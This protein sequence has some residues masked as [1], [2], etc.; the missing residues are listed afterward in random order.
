MRVLSCRWLSLC[1]FPILALILPGAAGAQTATVPVAA[2]TYLRSGSANQNQGQEILLRLQSSGRNRA[3]LRFDQAAIAAAVGSG[4]LVSAH[5]ELVIAGNGDNWGPDGRTVDAH[6]LSAAWTEVGATWNCPVDANPGNSQPDCAAQWDGGGFEE[7]PSDTVLHTNGQAG[8]VRFEVTA[9]VRAFLAGTA[10]QGWLI[11]KTDEGQN[12]RVDYGSRQ[13]PAG[14]AP[15]LVLVVESAAFDQVPPAL[16]ITEPAAVVINDTTPQVAV[17]YGDGGSG[18]APASLLVRVD[19]VLAAC[20]AG[21]A[22][23]VCEPAAAL[24]AGGHTIEARIADQAGNVATASRGFDLLIG[25]GFASTSVP[26]VADTTLR[27]GQPNQPQGAESVLRVRQ[28]GRNRALVRFDGAALAAALGS[29]TLRSASL[30]LSVERNGRN[31][32]SAGRTVGAHRLTA[33]W[34]E[35]GATWSCAADANPANQQPDCNPQWGGGSFA[36]AATA[37]VLHTNSLAGTVEFDVT[38]DVAAFLAGTANHGWLLK[39]AD[40]GKSGLVEY[41]SREGA[42]AQAP[43]LVVTFEVPG[44]GGDDVPP[45]L[46][47]TAPAAR[48]VSEQPA[49]AITLTYADAGSG[50]DPAS[51]ELTLDGTVITPSCTLDAAG[52]HCTS[53]PLASGP[54]LLTAVL[55]DRAGNSA[56]ANLS[57][58]LILDQLPPVLTITAPADGTFLN[59]T[60]TRIVGTVTDDSGLPVAVAVN[61]RAASVLG[62]TF[63]VYADLG[64]GGNELVAVATDATGKQATARI[65]VTLDSRPPTLEVAAPVPGQRTNRDTVRVAGQAEDASGIVELLVQGAPAPLAGNAFVQDVAL[66]EGANQL[67]V[68]ATDAAGNARQVTLEVTRFTLPGVSI[69][70]PA[71]L[72]T[73]AATAVEVRGTVSGAAVVTVN[74]IA[75]SVAGTQFVA[76]DV[77]LIEGGNTLTATA[78]GPDGR[79]GSDSINVVR[80]L[81]PPRVV[82]RHPRA[83]ATLFEPSVTVSGMVN[84]L[85]AGTVNATQATVTVNGRAAAVANRSFVVAGVPLSAGDNVLA[86]RAEDA[87][88]NVGQTQVVVR[89]APATVPRV[90]TVSGDGQSG[91]IS[92][93]LPQPL[94]VALLDA[95]GQPVVGRTVVFKVRG[96]DGSLDPGRRQVAVTTD[97]AGR[98]AVRFTL[99]T[100]AGAGNQ[101]VE[102]AAV[103]FSGPA[104]FTATALHGAPALIV[105]DAGDQQV[106]IA[107]QELP[108]PFVATVTDHGFNRL[109]EVAVTFRVTSGA[110]RFVNGLQVLSLTTDSDGRAITTLVLD[111]AEGIAT[112]VVKATIDG[113]ADGPTAT[114]TATGRGAGDR[115]AT[116]ISGVVLDNSNLPVPGV[117]LRLRDAASTAQTDARGVF[118]IA[119]APV[120]TVHLIVDG[121]TATVPG[122]WPDLEFVLTTIPGRDNDIG[123]PIYLL[124]L[125]L[126][127]GLFVDEARGGTLTLSAVP[128]FALEVQPGSVTFPGGSRSGLVSVTAVHSDKVPMVPNFG[129]QP[130]FIVTIQPAGARSSRPRG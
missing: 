105:V 125:D 17:T 75:A 58:E 4:S 21:P 31:W 8:A 39:K 91:V 54:H 122:S 32:G 74:G 98:A 30:V 92:T 35:A 102:A 51:F 80:D 14:S 116:S 127:Q 119:G 95:A 76:V 48:V 33:P 129:Q 84:D 22:G 110:G 79:V 106:G 28:S 121:S 93:A 83:G 67:T 70:S 94:V 90:V 46:A 34:T 44:G 112:N 66:A 5:L 57:F 38:A 61:G 9:D 13:G 59:T 15:R 118:R 25:P 77:P 72:S 117:T 104:I 64:E 128:G 109:E 78:A 56:T 2:D 113:L 6:R 97:S 18:V 126:G 115:A 120:G 43:K 62:G 40:E 7:E 111:P 26:A 45:S 24:A 108:R 60:A 99:G 16:A 1:L 107:G 123:M 73:I 47:F 87:S 100:W 52:A 96:N 68:R 53:P 63:N 36:P 29:G 71:D 101:V 3:L 81:T 88:G 103:G 37:S 19:G 11:K 69:T 23:A 12:G 10:N 85:V 42:A 86:V 124:P 65:A 49:I 50:V 55:R 41:V 20:A 27:Q 82:V 114:F 89:L 130:R